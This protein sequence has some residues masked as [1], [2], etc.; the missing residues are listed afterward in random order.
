M[1]WSE[2]QSI[3][4]DSTHFSLSELILQVTAKGGKRHVMKKAE[5]ETQKKVE[6]PQTNEFSCA[7]ASFGNCGTC[8][9]DLPPSERN[10]M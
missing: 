1:D 3:L 5:K 9:S 4:L 6:L 7:K 2:Q 10:L 8:K